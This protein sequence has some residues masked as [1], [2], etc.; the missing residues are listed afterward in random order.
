MKKSTVVRS[1]GQLLGSM[2]Q[3][4]LLLTGA[5]IGGVAILAGRKD[6]GKSIIKTGKVIGKAAG[7][8]TK[9][10]AKLAGNILEV[11]SDEGF[12]SGKRLG[13]KFVKTRVKI[14]GDP[15]AFYSKD[16]IIKADYN[17][18]IE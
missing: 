17:E 16:K 18:V 4:N 6:L 9:L 5:V 2:L 12:V 11:A 7:K 3:Y 1:T 8:A 10:S 14:Y 15:H 13:E